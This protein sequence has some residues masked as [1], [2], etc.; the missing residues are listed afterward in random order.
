MAKALPRRLGRPSVRGFCV[1]KSH[2]GAQWGGLLICGAPVPEQPDFFAFRG[3]WEAGFTHSVVMIVRKLV[4]ARRNASAMGLG[5]GLSLAAS[6]AA[7]QQGGVSR[8]DAGAGSASSSDAEQQQGTQARSK[9][10][11]TLREHVSCF[12]RSKVQQQ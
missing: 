4:H 10:E 9:A 11:P 12:W 8:T 7:Q 5:V 2:C 1:H 3:A 6:L